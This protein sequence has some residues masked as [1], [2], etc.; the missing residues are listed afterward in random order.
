MEYG[1]KLNDMIYNPDLEVFKLE[2]LS[3]ELGVIKFKVDEPVFYLKAN[4][5]SI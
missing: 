1:M 5:L 3:E 4:G 2:E